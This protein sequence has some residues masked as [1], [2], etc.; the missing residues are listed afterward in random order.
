MV[1]MK[2]QVFKEESLNRW[3]ELLNEG[4]DLIVLGDINDKTGYN[5]PYLVEMIKAV[6]DTPSFDGVIAVSPSKDRLLSKGIGLSNICLPDEMQRMSD[7]A[8]EAAPSI[9]E[10]VRATVNKFLVRSF[11]REK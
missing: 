1:Y 11:F 8:V 7:I 9:A 2:D 6:A 10:G 4:P 5:A 3:S